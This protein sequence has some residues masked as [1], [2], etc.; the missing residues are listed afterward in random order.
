ML[1]RADCLREAKSA[2]DKAKP[3]VLVYDPVRGGAPLEVIKQDECPGE[4]QGIFEDRKV[5]EWHRIKV[6][7]AQ[8]S[9]PQYS[10]ACA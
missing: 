6:L 1:C 4:L 5:I 7:V 8:R 10:R 2:V 3:L 9:C